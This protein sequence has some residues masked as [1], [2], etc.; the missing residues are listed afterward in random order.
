MAVR[1]KKKN[2]EGCLHVFTTQLRKH[3][4]GIG[5]IYNKDS[6]TFNNYSMSN[7]VIGIIV[8]LNSS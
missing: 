6:A 7:K 2:E 1:L 4:A 8:L 5:S 3:E